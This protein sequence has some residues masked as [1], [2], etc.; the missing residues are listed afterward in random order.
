MLLNLFC[1]PSPQKNLWVIFVV[2]LCCSG[3]CHC[4]DASFGCFGSSVSFADFFGPLY[5]SV[6]LM[7]KCHDMEVSSCG[8]VFMWLCRYVAVLSY[9]VS[10]LEFH[11][12]RI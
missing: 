5:C 1:L 12:V 11:V 3:F 8:C 4:V 6:Y 10:V 7:L 2:V 9:V